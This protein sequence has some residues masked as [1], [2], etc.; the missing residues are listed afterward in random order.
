MKTKQFRKII[1]KLEEKFEVVKDVN[2]HYIYDIRHNNK[3]IRWLTRSHSL[4]DKHDQ[5]IADNLD[6][7][8]H[9]LKNFIACDL[10]CEEYIGL[11]V[12]KGYIKED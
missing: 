6:L 9:Q 10:S 3:V 2:N 8:L 1:K 12:Q 11:L 4:K 7:S 5:L